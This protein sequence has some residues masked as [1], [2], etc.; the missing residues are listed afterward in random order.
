MLDAR[1]IRLLELL[2][3]QIKICNKCPTLYKRKCLPFWTP[4]SKY[5]ILAEA[6][7]RNEV[8]DEPLIGT[9]G[10]K[11]WAVMDIFGLRKEEFAI[12]NSIQCR[13]VTPTGSNGKPEFEQMKNCFPWIRKFIKILEPQK[14]LVLGNY[15]KGVID[16][17]LGVKSLVGGIMSINS[18]YT[19]NNIFIRNLPV[20][21]SIHPSMCI[22]KG[23]EGRKL[24]EKSVKI[25]NNLL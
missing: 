1:Q 15:A 23:E 8:D 24:L 13:P 20:V 17:S 9:A 25:F 3:D 6:P 14:M 7:G 12:I 18:T 11:L 16:C 19:T 10:Q 4:L 21:Y 5:L 22:Y 2:E